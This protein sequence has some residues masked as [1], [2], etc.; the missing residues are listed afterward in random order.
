MAKSKSAIQKAARKE[1][2]SSPTKQKIY[3]QRFKSPGAVYV[4]GTG[5]CGQLGLGEDV[6]LAKKPALVESLKKMKITNIACGG[7]HTLVLTDGGEVYSWGCND[8]KALGHSA[9]ENTV[10]KVGFLESPNLRFID[11]AA[12]DSVS[13]ALCN[14]GLLYAWGTFRDSKGL[15]GFSK[16]GEVVENP[17]VV[18]SLR[19]IHI[20]RIYAGGNHVMAITVDGRVFAWGTSEQG[21]LGRRV[22]ERHC[23]DALHPMA[24]KTPRSPF[25]CFALGS[26]HT[27]AVTADGRLFSWGLN[28]RGQLGLGD[29]AIR[30]TPVEVDRDLF[31]GEAIVGIA[32]GSHHSLALTAAGKVFGF[33][34]GDAH[35]LGVSGVEESTTP[36]LVGSLPPGIRSIACGANHNFAVSS[37]SS[38]YA[39]GYGELAQLGTG[40]EDDVATPTPLSLTTPAIKVSA[41]GQFS[42][43]LIKK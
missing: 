9:E 31:Q 10:G 41:G 38:V 6:A 12:G 36:I 4:C 17:C 27:L 35:Q 14:T 20:S 32:A 13:L 29:H 28:N 7:M 42:V 22:L 18:E 34:S 26:C 11:V 43:F 33:G 37:D 3:D 25:V 16:G 23:H 2:A 8:D 30:Y 40:M 1:P 19:H 39:W 21:Q 5:D 24:L 15:L